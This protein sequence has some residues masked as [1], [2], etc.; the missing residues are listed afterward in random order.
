MIYGYMRVSTDNQT[1]ENQKQKIASRFKIDHWV[2]DVGTGAK[3]QKGLQV[4]IEATLIKGD[5]L[6]ITAL[7]RLGRSVKNCAEIAEI[8]S[9][10]GVTLISLREGVDFSTSSGQLAFNIMISMAEF[11]RAATSER[12][13]DGLARVKANGKK[14]GPPK[15]NSFSVELEIIQSF[16]YLQHRYKLPYRESRAL[17][18]EI[19]GAKMSTGYLHGLTLKYK[20]DLTGIQ[21]PKEKLDELVSVVLQR[22]VEIEKMKRLPLFASQHHLLEAS[23]T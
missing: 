12:V 21:Y 18:Q 8:L 17:L 19:F 1:L 23:I 3:V 6:I 7:D 13:K 20:D 10:K 5:T 9:M 14:Q 15:K 22:R 2:E 11:E 4:L 16:K